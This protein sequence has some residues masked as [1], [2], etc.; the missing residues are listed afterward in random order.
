GAL[1]AVLL[2]GVVGALWWR[3]EPA[4]SGPPEKSVT[5]VDDGARPGNV[6][7]PKLLTG[8]VL[9]KPGLQ[10]Q[11]YPSIREALRHAASGDHIAVPPE[12]ITELLSL[13]VEEGSVRGVVIEGEAAWG[14][15]V[16]WYAPAQAP[17][18]RPLVSLQG[19]AGLRLRGFTFDGENRL[20]D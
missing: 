9:V 20:K 2:G 8:I 10:Q 16:R 19:V 15:P 6:P 17:A 4:P 3:S 5:V 12:T 7:A 14:K 11:S 18:E 13:S 1:T